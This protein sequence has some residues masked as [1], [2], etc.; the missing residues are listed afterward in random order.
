MSRVFVIPDVG[1]VVRGKDHST[2]ING[3]KKVEEKKKQDTEFD[4]Q[5]KL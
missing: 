1:N 5:R 2:V 4:E 3:I